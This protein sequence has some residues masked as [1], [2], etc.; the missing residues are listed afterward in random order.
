MSHR[1]EPTL[2]R[3]MREKTWSRDLLPERNLR[4]CLHERRLP[5][6]DAILLIMSVSVE[7]PKNVQEIKRLGRNAGLTEIQRWNISDILRK[8]KG[9]AIRLPLGW[10]L[11]SHGRETAR[12]LDVFPHGQSARV[13]NTAEDLRLAMS[14]VADENSM[15]FLSEAVTCF[16]GG[17]LRACAVLSW[18]GAVALLYRYVTDHCLAAFN[19]EASR[20]DPK[21]RAANITDDLARMKEGDFVRSH[22]IAAAEHHWE[23]RQ[24]GAQKQLSPTPQRMWT[25]ELPCHRREQGCGTFRNSHSKCVLE[26]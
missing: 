9:L 23:E 12:S 24:G 7:T 5:R 16:E 19:D 17:Q 26:I 13:V 20:R 2:Y 21:W 18:A 14:K 1:R 25:S 11:T 22:R 4:N 15:R 10:V 8:A 3:Q 6:R